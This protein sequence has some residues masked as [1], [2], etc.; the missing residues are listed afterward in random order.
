MHQPIL[1]RQ[2]HSNNCL[3]RLSLSPQLRHYKLYSLVSTCYW[4]V[5][6]IL[7]LT[8]FPS[9][10]IS[11]QYV[12][13]FPHSI[14]GMSRSSFTNYPRLTAIAYV[15]IFPNFFLLFHALGRYLDLLAD[16]HVDDQEL[17]YPAAF[18]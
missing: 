17:Q 8:L 12:V 6:A 16:V 3:S 1:Y 5:I 10:L 4:Y 9:L 15:I 14:G 11:S 13:R 18:Q 2:N 7:S